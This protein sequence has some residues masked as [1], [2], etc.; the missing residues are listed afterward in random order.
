MFFHRILRGFYLQNFLRTFTSYEFL[1]IT[2]VFEFDIE[3]FKASV[4]RRRVYS[5]LRPYR[6][7]TAH[8]ISVV[9]KVEFPTITAVYNCLCYVVEFAYNLL[10][11]II[12]FPTYLLVV[13]VT[14]SVIF[15]RIFVFCEMLAVRVKNTAKT[16]LKDAITWVIDYSVMQ[17]PRDF[18][19]AS[20]KSD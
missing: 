6:M 13:G 8:I 20:F 18:N 16:T 17:S 14:E 12:M 2:Y 9:N 1:D 3:C 7:F 4:I 10:S 15:D 11:H 5:W 19:N